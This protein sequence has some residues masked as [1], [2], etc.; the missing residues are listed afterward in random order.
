MCQTEHILSQRRHQRQVPGEGTSDG[1]MSIDNDK[2]SSKRPYMPFDNDLCELSDHDSNVEAP[3][4]ARGQ[5]VEP[6]VCSGPSR[7]AKRARVD[8]SIKDAQRSLSN[9][10]I[11]KLLPHECNCG[12]DCTSF[13]TR[14][15]TLRWRAATCDF[16]RHG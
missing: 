10:S 16:C 13:I 9:K 3:S 4:G 11:G 2:E 5:R 12:K 8:L 14:K 15:D 7:E 6:E 1:E